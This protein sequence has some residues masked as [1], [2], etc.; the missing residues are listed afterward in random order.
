VSE[1]IGR[2]AAGNGP[3]SLPP[4]AA[5]GKGRRQRRPTGAPPPP[6]P[7]MTTPDR[8][9]HVV[10]NATGGLARKSVATPFNRSQGLEDAQN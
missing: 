6:L 2:L 3:A 4:G 9:K 8:P 10:F 1:D 5:A 7:A